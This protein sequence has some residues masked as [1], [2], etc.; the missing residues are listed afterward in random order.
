[1]Y[2]CFD[3]QAWANVPMFQYLS[4]GERTHVWIFEHRPMYR[5]QTQ[6]KVPVLRYSAVGQHTRIAVC[7]EKKKH[8]NVP[9]SPWD[10]S[11]SEQLRGSL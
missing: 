5:I 9:T 6:A 1:M 10:E 3:I 4:M 2:L 8:P 7:L 11:P